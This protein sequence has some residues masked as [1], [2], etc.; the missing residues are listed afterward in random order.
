M[1]RTVR[2]QIKQLKELQAAMKAGTTAIE[3]APSYT[4]PGECADAHQK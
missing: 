2:I 4:D 3:P 1:A